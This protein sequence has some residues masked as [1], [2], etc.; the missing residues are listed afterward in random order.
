MQKTFYLAALSLLVLAVIACIICFQLGRQLSNSQDSGQELVPQAANRKVLNLICELKVSMPQGDL[1]SPRK[2]YTQTVVANIDFSNLSGWY[3]GQFAISESRKGSVTT[4]GS[5]LHVRR[6]ALF[7][8][9]GV[10]IGGEE[11][12]IDRSTG[13]FRQKITLQDVRTLEL[14]IGY[15]GKYAKAPF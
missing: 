15:C 13:E 14:M 4:E 5:V 8:R 3:Q 2:N 10:M 9:F 1:A 11:F 6:P 7:P 12:T